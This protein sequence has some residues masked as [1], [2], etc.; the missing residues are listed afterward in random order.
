MTTA[1]REGY[2]LVGQDGLT[3]HGNPRLQ[4]DVGTTHRL[5]AGVEPVCC[6]VGFHYCPRALDCVRCVPR[7]VLD[8]PLRLLRVTVPDD[9]AVVTNAVQRGWKCA[10]SALTAVEDVTADIDELL[11]GVVESRDDECQEWT[12]YRS[13]KL[14]LAPSGLVCVTHYYDGTRVK[15]W[16]DGGHLRQEPS[17]DIVD[18]RGD[19]CEEVPRGSDRWADLDAELGRIDFT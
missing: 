10:A 9:A 18:L 17:G 16:A 19:T 4:F 14:S 3:F 2:K 1:I 5:P 11:T 7:Q 6:Q 8:E 13:G 15:E 12:L